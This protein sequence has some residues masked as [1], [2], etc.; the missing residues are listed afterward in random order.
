MIAE[1]IPIRGLLEC[2]TD[3]GGGVAKCQRSLSRVAVERREENDQSEVQP[4][5]RDFQPQPNS[6]TCGHSPQSKT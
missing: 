4:E 5:V 6:H 3:V 1:S 2:D